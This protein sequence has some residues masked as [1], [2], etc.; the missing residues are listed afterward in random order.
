M[1][2]REVSRAANIG[3]LIPLLI[4]IEQTYSLQQ[5]PNGRIQPSKLVDGVPDCVR[6]VL[7]LLHQCS[8][9]S[10]DMSYIVSNGADGGFCAN[11]MLH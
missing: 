8:R 1:V 11:E 5:S 7:R 2:R 9:L 3:A 10:T 6:Q 4:A